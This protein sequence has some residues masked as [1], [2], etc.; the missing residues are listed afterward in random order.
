MS[1]IH[2]ITIILLNQPLWA[3]AYGGTSRDWAFSV[4]QIANGSYLIAGET[5]GFGAGLGDV[6][7]INL[8]SF[9]NIN[10]A[11][12]IGGSNYDPA[13]C[14]IQT[15]DGGYAIAGRTQSYGAGLYDAYVFKLNPALSLSWASVFGGTGQDRFHS[16]V[17]TD[18]GGYVAVGSTNSFTGTY[19]DF[20][21]VRLDASGGLVWARAFG[22]ANS[23]DT[24]YAVIE[25]PDGYVVAGGSR[26]GIYGW[27]F[28]VLKLDENG[29]LL[30][31]KAYRG[32]N[33]EI[34]HSLIR[35]PDGCYLV[36]GWTQSFGAGNWDYLVIKIDE[37]GNLIWAKTYGGAG[38]DDYIFS[39]TET[40][41]GGFAIAGASFSFGAGERDFLVIKTDPLGNLIW[42]RTFGGASYDEAWSIV[43]SPDGCFTVVGW[44]WN[45]GAGNYDVIA[46]RLDPSGN[47]A[48]CVQPCSPSVLEP[49]PDVISVSGLSSPALSTASPTPSVGI[50][51]LTVTDACP[52][53][54]HEEHEDANQQGIR[55]VSGP[56][57]VIFFSPLEADIAIYSP[58]GRLIYSGK[59]MK[60]Q[61]R[62]LLDRGLYFWQAGSYKGKVVVW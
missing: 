10:W 33:D 37:S 14:A 11:R 13:Y 53:L 20:L 31:A 26:Q 21:M 28:L 16:V 58:D 41:D 30:W 7:L 46:M 40:S 48:G 39:L 3:K 61:N 45:F 38:H 23:D 59:V 49:S 18:D 2:A 56:G 35:T 44:S 54:A 32:G 25:A 1:G 19:T 22:Q 6:L 9:G 12:T 52:P 36:G 62:I 29:N 15:S 4:T 24:A 8:D 42:A 47:Y 60:G 50:P 34:A 57:G 17:Q 55:C 51:S 27:D 43:Q 5:W